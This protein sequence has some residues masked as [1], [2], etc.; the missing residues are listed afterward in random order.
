MT[1]ETSATVLRLPDGRDLSF[2]EYG[3]SDGIPVFGFHGTPGSRRQ[4]APIEGM[5]VPGGIRI[6]APD[7][8]GYGFS[9]FQPGRRLTDWPADVQ[10]IAEHLGLERFGIFGVSGGGPHALVCAH[11][12]GERLLG[13]AC[14][15]GIGPLQEVDAAEGMNRANRLITRLGKSSP[16]LMGLLM[17][18]QIAAMRRFADRLFETFIKILPE[19]DQRLVRRPAIREAFTDELRR[20]PRTGGRAAAQDFEVF[21][22]DWGFRLEDIRIPIHFW[23]GDLDRNVPPHHVHILAGSMPRATI[24][25]CPGAGHMLVLER[26]DEI[27]AVASGKES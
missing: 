23:Q 8:P 2:A 17:R 26:L 24:H 18:L 4:M 21:A 3:D 13:A 16:A 20:M 22:S 12:F 9:S 27:L 5:S 25:D 7:R 14:V 6:I 15:S 19:P 11:A 10:A 1:T